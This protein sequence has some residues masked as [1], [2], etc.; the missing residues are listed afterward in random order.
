MNFGHAARRTA[1]VSYDTW[2]VGG[3]PRE[4]LSNLSK[5][6]QVR[7]SVPVT[8]PSLGATLGEALHCIPGLLPQHQL[9]LAQSAASS[10]SYRNRWLLLLRNVSVC[11]WLYPSCLLESCMQHSSSNMLFTLSCA[12]K[13]QT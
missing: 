12:A 7:A 11:K 1:I 5:T 9:A 6:V 3:D 13:V 8:R 2:R 4:N 10:S